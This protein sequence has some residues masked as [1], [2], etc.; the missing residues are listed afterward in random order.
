MIDNDRATIMLR[1]M[2]SAAKADGRAGGEHGQR[3]LARL[4]EAGAAPAARQLVI[5]ELA[6][7]LDLDG[8]VATVGSQTLAVQV[9]AA[10]LLAIAV[11]TPAE[12]SYL[13][14][15]G[16]RL[17]LEPAFTRELHRRLGIAPVV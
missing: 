11:A 5:D 17:G 1:A 12:A 7:P 16:E 14:Q 13:R 8:L 10:S 2:V 6:R 15:L 4:D 9:Y 3:I